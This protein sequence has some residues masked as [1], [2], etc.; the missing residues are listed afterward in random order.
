MKVELMRRYYISLELA[1]GGT[2]SDWIGVP[3]VNVDMMKEGDV[4]H[5]IK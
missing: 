4:I 5:C 3:F 1:L 2:L